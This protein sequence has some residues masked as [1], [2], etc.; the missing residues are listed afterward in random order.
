MNFYPEYP[1]SGENGFD[2][3]GNKDVIKSF[4]LHFTDK[5]LKTFVGIEES[6]HKGS[7]ILIDSPGTYKYEVEVILIS[8]YD[9]RD[10]EA[11]TEYGERE[12]QECKDKEWRQITEQIFGCTPPWLSPHNVCTGNYTLSDE[13]RDSWNILFRDIYYGR[14]KDTETCKKACTV[15]RS[16][17]KPRKI[18]KEDKR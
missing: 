16:V 18:S 9:P 6:T 14:S 17:I 13:E 2:I 5:K 3:K 1:V 15:T 4:E 11:C 12:Y 7:E 10:P 8:N